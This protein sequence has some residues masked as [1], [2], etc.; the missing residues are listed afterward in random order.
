LGSFHTFG[1]LRIT[2]LT[3]DLETKARKVW[4]LAPGAVF[5]YDYPRDFFP[6]FFRTVDSQRFKKF[7]VTMQKGSGENVMDFLLTFEPR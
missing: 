6:V 7:N 4:A 3:P 1:Q 5:D 2:G